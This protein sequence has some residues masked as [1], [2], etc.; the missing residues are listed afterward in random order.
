MK[1]SS[2]T[3]IYLSLFFA[4]IFDN[5][6]SF[7]IGS[8]YLESN[9]VY[10]IFGYWIFALP[11]KLR[12]FH[13]FTMGLIIDLLSGS[14]IGFYTSMFVF[15]SYIIHVYAYTFRLFSYLQLSI[16]FGMTATFITALKFLISY[17]ESYSYINIFLSLIFNI[18]FWF[19]IYKI[20]RF[21]RQ[22]YL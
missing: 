11:E 2:I 3:K 5:I 18:L 12:V 15:F 16:F 14:W 7:Q 9:L 6:F 10:L 4:L 22:R 8:Y 20:M 17:P 13:S 19:P 21:Y 1:K